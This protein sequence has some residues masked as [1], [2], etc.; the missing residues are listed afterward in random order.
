MVKEEKKQTLVEKA[1]AVPARSYKKTKYESIEVLDLVLEWLA[2]RL[3]TKQVAEVL[4]C[5]R[6]N[7]IHYIVASVIRKHIQ[8]LFFVLPVVLVLIYILDLDHIKRTEF[9]WVP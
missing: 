4:E 3:A 7:N 5:T 6:I 2:G 8:T 9:E 1:R